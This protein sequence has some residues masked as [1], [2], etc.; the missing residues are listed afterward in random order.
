MASIKGWSNLDDSIM[1]KL[2]QD[3]AGLDKGQ[4]LH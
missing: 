4:V 3:L 1:I 2:M